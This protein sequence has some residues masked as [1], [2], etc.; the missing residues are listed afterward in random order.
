MVTKMSEKNTPSAR[1]TYP[2]GFTKIQI[3][4]LWI[5]RTVFSLNSC[6]KEQRPV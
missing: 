6:R 4:S 5:N 2:E 3:F 1:R